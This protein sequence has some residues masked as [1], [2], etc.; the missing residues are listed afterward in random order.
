VPGAARPPGTARP[1]D[2]RQR[3]PPARSGYAVWHSFRFALGDREVEELLAERG[4]VPTEETVHRWCRTFGQAYARALRRR[5]ARPGATWHRDAVCSANNGTTHSRWPAVDQDGQ[6][7]ASL[8]QA[9]RD[10]A[11]A[12][13]FLRKGRT[14]LRY[15]PG[16][17]C[18]GTR[19]SDGAAD[20]AAERGTPAAHG[21]E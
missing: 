7:R 18:T 6:G 12:T 5:R 3:C 9:R 4:A 21:R 1:N 16:V 15:V 8:V 10:E 19:A 2:K 13:A 20:D 17:R 11:A 14:N